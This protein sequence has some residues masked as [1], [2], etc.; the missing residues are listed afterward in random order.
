M[1]GAQHVKNSQK[2]DSNR[3]LILLSPFFV[4]QGHLKACLLANEARSKQ[5]A[6]RA[7]VVKGHMSNQW[8][9]LRPLPAAQIVSRRRHLIEVPKAVAHG[10][11]PC[12][13]QVLDCYALRLADS[14]F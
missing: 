9:Q 14:S 2:H 6:C 1:C 8:H 13:S 10:A 5:G 12:A 7:L 11:A 4:V 3:H